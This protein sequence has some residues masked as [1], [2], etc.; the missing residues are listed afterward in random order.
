[1]RTGPKLPR[2]PEKHPLCSERKPDSDELP[3]AER[4]RNLARFAAR[5]RKGLPLCEEK[6]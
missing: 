3:A 4:A 2:P 1:M 5:A 6:P